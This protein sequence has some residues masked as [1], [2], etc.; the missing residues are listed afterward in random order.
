MARNGPRR[1]RLPGL[2]ARTRA[3][4]TPIGECTREAD[5]ECGTGGY[6]RTV[7]EPGYGRAPTQPQFFSRPAIHLNTG[8]LVFVA[9]RWGVGGAPKARTSEQYSGYLVQQGG[10]CGR[11][12]SRFLAD[13]PGSALAPTNHNSARATPP[14]KMKRFMCGEWVTNTRAAVVTALQQR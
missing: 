12:L 3:Q 5:G 2:K 13:A 9:P 7:D 4:R 6:A 8:L 11:F 1:S 14:G 10:H